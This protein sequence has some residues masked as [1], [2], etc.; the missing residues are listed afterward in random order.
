MGKYKKGYKIQETLAIDLH[1]KADVP[2]EACGLAEVKLFQK[3]IPEFQIHVLS[4][5]HFNGVIYIK[6]Q[7][8]EYLF[9]CITMM[10]TLT[11][12]LS[13]QDF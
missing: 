3:A 11:L 7:K 6:V 10:N 12:S 9:I 2:L 4:K 5:E 1:H 8:G 13:L